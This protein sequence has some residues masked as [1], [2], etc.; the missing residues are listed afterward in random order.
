MTTVTANLQDIAGIPDNASWVFTTLLRGSDDGDA[1]VTSRKVR[2]KPT[3][4]VLT[5]DLDPGYSEVLFAG[6]KFIIDVPDTGTPDLW[7]LLAAAIAAPPGTPAD[8]IAAAVEAYLADNPPVSDDEY[9]EYANEAAFPGTGVAD[10]IYVAVDTG[11]LYRWT[12][13]VYTQIGGGGGGGGD[14]DLPAAIHAATG[15]TTPVDADELALADSAASYV[16]KKLTF[17]NLKAWVKAWIVKA[18]VGLGSVDNTADTAKPVSTAQQ[19]ALDLKAPLASPTFTGT[20]AGVTK[21]HVGLGSVDNTADTAKPVSTAQQTALNKKVEVVTYSGS[22]SATRPTADAVYWVDFPSTPT[23]AQAQDIIAGSTDA[24]IVA[25]AALTPTNDDLLQRKSGAWTNRTPAQVKTDLA[26]TRAD[27]G[28]DSYTAITTA[29]GTTT[30]TTSSTDVL[31]FTGSTTQT[32]ALPTTSIAA[33]R[34]FTL[35]NNSTGLVT[36]NASGGA[37]VLLL[38]STWGANVVALQ[39]TP[40]TAAHWQVLNFFPTGSSAI[41]AAPTAFAIAQR[42][43]A[44]SLTSTAFLPGFTAT[45]TAAGTTTLT[46]AS[47]EVQLFFGSTTQTIT[48][49]A[50]GMAAA[51]QYRIINASTGALTVNA[52]G[53]GLVKTVPASSW[54]TVIVV[55]GTPTPTSA[56][57][58]FAQY[59]PSIDATINAQTG[60]TYTLAVADDGKVITL[61]NASAITVTVPQDSAAAIPIG[62]Y[63]ECIQLGAGQVTFA[64]GTGATLNSRGTAL[65]INAQYGVAGLRKT[66]A[67]TFVLA[68]DTTT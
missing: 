24:D 48:L 58:W 45:A 12:G 2:V 21:A 5:V 7:D 53:G 26:L 59:P 14:F 15:K 16:L 40:T 41:A 35:I 22:L 57:N 51:Q 34:R 56:A 17:A 64:A 47:N 36:V 37:Q 29:A 60:T 66:S 25:I 10:R 55:D 8:A 61:S 49:P 18:D 52:S 44:G 3:S 38:S 19:T 67:N 4:G 20:V 23:N 31:V 6:Q 32:L 1:I 30:M 27:V 46:S 33:G 62:A 68:G 54:A 43:G 50:S 39:A 11:F 63:I 42:D 28:V 13:S 9:H 65:K